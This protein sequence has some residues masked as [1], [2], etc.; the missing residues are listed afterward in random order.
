MHFS[1]PVLLLASALT[2]TSAAPAP[3]SSAVL[4]VRSPTYQLSLLTANKQ[5]RT[6]CSP[7]SSHA[8]SIHVT[9]TLTAT[10]GDV[11]TAT[12]TLTCVAAPLNRYVLLPLNSWVWTC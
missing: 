10:P 7:A 2:L 9:L 5:S 8:Q 3:G 6:I 1:T 11:V 12:S 4:K